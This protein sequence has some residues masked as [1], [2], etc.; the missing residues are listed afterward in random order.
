MDTKHPDTAA[1]AL[2]ALKEMA[3]KVSFETVQYHM[4]R[5]PD[6]FFWRPDPQ[7]EGVWGFFK[8]VA[9]YKDGILVSPRCLVVVYLA[10]Y[11][12]PF[13]N[14]RENDYFEMAV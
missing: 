10:G 11:K 12:E 14:I 2:A 13:G 7:V 8:Q 6:E 4:N 1:G 9:K 3:D 5:Y